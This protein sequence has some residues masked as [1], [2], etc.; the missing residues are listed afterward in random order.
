MANLNHCDKSV[1]S[2]QKVIFDDKA[3][4]YNE[5]SLP[6]AGKIPTCSKLVQG[7]DL[8]AGVDES[9]G[10][11]GIN[12]MPSEGLCVSSSINTQSFT[13]GLHI[14]GVKIQQLLNY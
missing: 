5:E 12:S 11:L 1:N 3:L 13:A 9:K 14:L 6:E 8:V 10:D 4:L 7:E 2:S